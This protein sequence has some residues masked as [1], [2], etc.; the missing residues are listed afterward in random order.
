M[1]GSGAEAVAWCQRVVSIANSIE[2]GTG[3]TINQQQSF[4]RVTIYFGLFATI[5]AGLVGLGKQ[6]WNLPVLV[7]FCFVLSLVYTD[8]LG[9][10]SLHKWVVYV[11]M[12]SGAGIAI[13]DFLGNSDSNKIIEVGNLLVYVQLPLMF[14]KK[15][16]RVFEQWGVFLLLEL[17]VG[18]LVNDNVLYGILMLPMLAIGCAAMMALA[19]FTSYLRHSESISES[20]AIWAKVLHWLGKEQLVTKQSSGVR[21]SAVE[22]PSLTRTKYTNYYSPSR[23]SSGVLPFA[24]SVLVFSVA[25]F[26]SL[27]RLNLGSYDGNVNGSARVGFNEQISLRMVGELLNNE[28]PLF[29]MSMRDERKQT[30]YRPELPPYIRATV[31]H[32]YIDGPRRG[33]WQPGEPG[34]LRDT[35]IMRDPPMSVQMDESFVR[36]RDA[37]TVQI[38]E[39]GSL[40]EVVPTIAPFSQHRTKL[41]FSVVK[42]DWRMLDT[43]ESVQLKNEKRRFS[44]TTYAF[45]KG[46]ES[47]LLPDL[48]DCL[49]EEER[50]GA[51]MDY[52]KSELLEF[53]ESLKAI[54]PV[55]DEILTKCPSNE[56]DKFARA[57]FIEDYLANG[58]D[59]TYT[60]KL[61]PQIDRNLD[62]IADFLINK[63]KGHCQFFAS[64]LAMILRSMDIPTRLVVGFRP[65]E[66]NDVGDYFLVQQSHAHVWVEAYFTAEELR[67]HSIPVPS[68]VKEGAWLRL[69]AT[70]PGDGSNAGGTFKSN[71]AQTLG[72]MQEYWSEMILNMDKSKQSTIFSLFSESSD[73]T[74]SEAWLALKSRYEQAR[75]SGFVKVLSSPSR[76]FSWQV[77]VGIIVLGC[78]LV[79]LHRV[80]LWL[81]PTWIPRIRIRVPFT[82]KPLSSVDFYNKAVR[83]LNRVGIE[84]ASY[85]TQREF[86]HAASNI[87]SRQS[88]QLD[89][90]LFSKLFYERRFGGL[91]SL[92]ESDQSRINQALQSL[93][94]DLAKR[95]SLRNTTS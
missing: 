49:V 47:P 4:I 23:W 60:L 77:A 35:R 11:A 32:R 90:E 73:G 19:Q 80:L 54:I 5:V 92:S 12:I 26:Y 22:S 39:K 65:S 70:P 43:R 84:R 16:K 85:Q 64:A 67:T 45:K 36:E 37:V 27:P 3:R 30:P 57:V 61:T 1:D 95:K 93:E 20:T 83:L 72:M 56:D 52:R 34:L 17:V 63:R 2:I 29:R 58:S 74:Y 13:A 59:F 46:I 40:G 53:P 24:F 75:N 10:F 55:R 44:Y 28:T 8:I 14:Q 86:F 7:G 69:D 38:I 71:S 82:Q 89:A 76:W 62:P 41:G 18:A 81:F 91:A 94:S 68:C 33:S 51:R 25:Y 78:L 88:I 21:L 48:L 31:S 15:S 87:L 6:S 50:K 9:W 79:A 66:Y 42:R